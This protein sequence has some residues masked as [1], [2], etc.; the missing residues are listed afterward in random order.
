MTREKEA[1][2][3]I[4]VDLDHTLLCIDLLRERL[5]IAILHEPFI[6]FQALYWLFRGGRAR[7]KTEFAA[8]HPLDVGG[9]P[10]NQKLLSL[11]QE[12]KSVG[13]K[14]ILATG[15]PRQWADAIAAHLGIFDRVLATT[16]ETGNLKA[17]RK[18][19]LILLDADELIGSFLRR[20]NGQLSLVPG[21]NWLARMLWVR[22]SFPVRCKAR[23]LG[24]R[25]F[26]CIS[27]VRI[28][29]FSCRRS[30]PTNCCTFGLRF[31]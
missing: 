18:L 14:L 26:V 9:L 28:C 21:R 10:F 31:C 16:L 12:R 4:Y 19:D 24:G 22:S 17:R 25:P 15:A 23:N 2:R 29:F 5:L 7:L 1:V 20:P 11:L 8:G 30:A 27:G 3:N 6:L 13:Q